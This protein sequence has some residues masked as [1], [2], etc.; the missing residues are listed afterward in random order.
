MPKRLYAHI[1]NSVKNRTW[2]GRSLEKTTM[3]TYGFHTDRP[4][5]K[6]CLRRLLDTIQEELDAK[7]VRKKPVKKATKIK[8]TTLQ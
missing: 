3:F 1:I 2:C 5:C 6:I 8:E 7:P 4:H